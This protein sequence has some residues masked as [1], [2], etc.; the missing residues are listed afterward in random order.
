LI[1][2]HVEEIKE[3]ANNILTIYDNGVESNVNC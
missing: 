2:S 3:A 1:I